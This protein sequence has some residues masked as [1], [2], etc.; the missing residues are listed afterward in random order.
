MLSI[1]NGLSIAQ[2]LKALGI[3][4]GI[5]AATHSGAYVAGY[6]VGGAKQEAK[7]NA[8]SLKEAFNL[9]QNMEKNN[10][11]YQNLSERHQCL[12]LMR[13][14]GLPDDECD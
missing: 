1:I 6:L 3:A 5:L 13:F 8:G 9:I 12:Y 7:Q 14:S 4:G 10:V 11:V 2:K